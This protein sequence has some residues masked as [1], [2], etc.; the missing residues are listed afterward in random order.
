MALASGGHITRAM[1]A[2]VA[3][4]PDAAGEETRTNGWLAAW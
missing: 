3:D 4:Q 2:A 1:A